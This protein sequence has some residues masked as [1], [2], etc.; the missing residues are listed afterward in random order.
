VESHLPATYDEISEA[1]V[2]DAPEQSIA[3]SGR[4]VG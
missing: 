1:G 2:Y 3:V 4:G